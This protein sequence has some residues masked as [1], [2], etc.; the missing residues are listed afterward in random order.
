MP[1]DGIEFFDNPVLAKLGQVERLLAT[2]DRWCKGALR[3]RRGRHCLVG[4]IALAD[5]RRELTK[6]ILQAAREVGRRHY[7]RIQSFNDDPGTTHV[8]VLRVIAR[9]RLA[10]LNNIPDAGRAGWSQRLRE[11]VARLVPATAADS[12]QLDQW[13]SEDLPAPVMIRA[14]FDRRREQ[15]R[16]PEE[17]CR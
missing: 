2:E 8:V 10:I 11:A 6:P 12:A 15:M 1:L 17:F 3:D 13:L 16:E 14:G 7:W 5:G 4:A 9:A